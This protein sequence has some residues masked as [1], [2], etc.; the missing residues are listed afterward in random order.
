MTGSRLRSA[1][2]GFQILLT[3]G[4]LGL[5]AWRVDIGEAFSTFSDA[6]WAWLPAG[7]IIFTLS[8]VLHAARWRIFL[9][10]HRSLPL[11]GLLGIFLIH[12]MVNAMLLLR[13]GDV[14]RIQTTAQRYKIARELGRDEAKRSLEVLLGRYPAAAIE[15]RKE[16]P[17][18]TRDVPAG[19]PWN[20]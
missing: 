5:L 10:S 11:S 4:F 9:G 13:A 14:V 19:L 1:R 6:Q 16:L 12:N 3:A 15:G 2:I 7:L 20:S 17:T 18:L 8:K